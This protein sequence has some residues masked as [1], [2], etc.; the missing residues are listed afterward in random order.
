MMTS[1]KNK[2]FVQNLYE[3]ASKPDGELVAFSTDGL[4]LR[5]LSKDKLPG[6]LLAPK[7]R[8]Y[9]N[10]QR[11]LNLHGFTKFSGDYVNPYFTQT[12]EHLH[13]IKR[14]TEPVSRD[15]HSNLQRLTESISMRAAA[16]VVK[17]TD[18]RAPKAAVH[19]RA[20]EAEAQRQSEAALDE[21]APETAAVTA[22]QK[23]LQDAVNNAATAQTTTGD[24]LQDAAT[25]MRASSTPVDTT[26]SSMLM[27][28]CSSPSDS[29]IASSTGTT[30]ESG[31]QR[32]AFNY[33]P[34]VCR[35]WP[36]ADYTAN[37]SGEPTVKEVIKQQLHRMWGEF[38]EQVDHMEID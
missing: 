11:Q 3:E 14:K 8:Q 35:H 9:T 25:S 38:M 36:S 5:I 29:D 13:L 15:L 19:E 21:R 34:M 28:Q 2:R 31:G 27:L 7:A 33:S 24:T 32:E 18:Q 23:T 26:A 12:G 6:S 30:L 1:S 17:A 4:R 16:Q 37:V 10:F 20:P 22:P